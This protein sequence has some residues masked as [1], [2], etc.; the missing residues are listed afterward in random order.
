MSYDTALVCV[1]VQVPVPAS[2]LI[3][4]S[5]L[6]ALP[7]APRRDAEL[8]ARRAAARVSEPV[9]VPAGRRP[10]WPILI[11]VTTVAAYLAAAVVL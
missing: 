4:D 2:R 1:E 10:V 11:V 3:S 7:P 9:R 8:V 6:A 5:E